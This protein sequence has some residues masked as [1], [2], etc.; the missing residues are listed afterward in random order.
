M[1]QD[2]ILKLLVLKFSLLVLEGMNEAWIQA[3]YQKMDKG[4]R[5]TLR[6]ALL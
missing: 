2:N 3:C 1:P 4:L 5:T 6:T